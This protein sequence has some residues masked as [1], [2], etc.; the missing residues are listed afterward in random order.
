VAVRVCGGGGGGGGGGGVCPGRRR[1]GPSRR[2]ES[3]ALPAVSGHTWATGQRPG[4]RARRR[5]GGRQPAQ[6]RHGGW[7]S[8]PEGRPPSLLRHC[9]A[10]P[11]RSDAG[12]CATGPGTPRRQAL[13][14]APH[15]PTAVQAARSG[16]PVVEKSGGDVFACGHGEG[17]GRTS[18]GTA[19]PR[20]PSSGARR[21]KYPPSPP[22]S[23]SPVPF[24]CR[25]SGQ[26]NPTRLG[27]SRCDT[28][29]PHVAY[30]GREFL[31]P[32]PDAPV[33]YKE[34]R[35]A[36]RFFGS[37]GPSGSRRTVS[38]Q[39]E[40]LHWGQQPLNQEGAFTSDGGSLATE[41]LAGGPGPAAD[42][43]LKH[44]AALPREPG[45]RQTAAPGL[46]VS[47]WRDSQPLGASPSARS[48]R[49]ARALRRWLRHREV[50]GC[51]S[52]VRSRQG[53]GSVAGPGQRGSRP[54]PRRRWRPRR[55]AGT[56][57]PHGLTARMSR[58]G[59]PAAAGSLLPIRETGTCCFIQGE[60]RRRG[61]SPAAFS[62]RTRSLHR[63][64]QLRDFR[65]FGY[66]AIMGVSGHPRP[67]DLTPHH[68]FA[69]VASP[70]PLPPRAVL[71]IKKMHFDARKRHAPAPTERKPGRLLPPSDCSLSCATPSSST[72]SVCSTL[73]LT[74]RR[75]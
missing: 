27:S 1:E 10:R 63:P 17:P 29:V 39:D 24:P 31:Y 60:G 68:F 62:A 34:A 38:G 50:A 20:S 8:V 7:E 4:S 23:R 40:V 12:V 65:R 25:L 53:P 51:G 58:A 66:G 44:E 70:P 3:E 72:S 41:G 19:P 42:P 26:R 54:R 22:L 36:L 43:D 75:R 14:S 67:S 73:T 11:P 64:F 61:G 56:P 6:S 5:S 57:P 35:A 37:S 33:T 49:G 71:F 18:A 15:P 30:T 52:E 55:Q 32:P 59:G 16:P 28:A 74:G 47:T 45:L 13:K 69:R 21:P 46:G 48:P 2:A 9:P